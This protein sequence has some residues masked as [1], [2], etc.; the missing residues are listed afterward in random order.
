VGTSLRGTS[1]EV[2]RLVQEVASLIPEA[3][4]ALAELP[5]EEEHA[6]TFG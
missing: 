3:A 2:M 6:P 4:P 1:D 5:I